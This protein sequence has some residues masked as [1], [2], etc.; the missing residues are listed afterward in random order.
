[1]LPSRTPFLV[2]LTALLLV[3]VSQLQG[4]VPAN[5]TLLPDS[6]K[7]AVLVRNVDELADAFNKTQ[8]GQLLNDPL[9]QPFMEDFERQMKEK[10]R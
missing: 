2:A 6:T 7:G 8:M 4:A 10:W 9:M 5:E 1:M 3:P